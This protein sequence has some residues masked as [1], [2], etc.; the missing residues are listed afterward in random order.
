[1]RQTTGAPTIVGIDLNPIGAFAN[2]FAHDARE[3]ID[4]VGFF[5]ALRH[6]PFGRVALGA[7][8]TGC[9]NRSRGHKHA[10]PGYDSLL[11]RLLQTDVAISGAFS[12]QI[13]HRG[14]AC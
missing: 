11:D 13:T 12:P 8:T 1:M 4:A 2:L 6:S 5:G 3:A 10:R 9:H 7:I 14:E